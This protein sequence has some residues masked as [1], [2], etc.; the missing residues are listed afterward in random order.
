MSAYRFFE[1]RVPNPYPERYDNVSG[2]EYVTRLVLAREPV[3]LLD[4]KNRK[5]SYIVAEPYTV[6]YL[7]DGRRHELTVPAGMLTD[8]ASVPRAA[9]NVV[10]RVG[11]HLEAAIVHDYLF[12]AWQLIDGR[13]TRRQ[14]F[15]FANAVMFAGLKAARVAYVE[16][17]AIEL[18][19]SLPFVPW[20]AYRS[21]DDVLF[22]QL[23]PQFAATDTGMT[24]PPIFV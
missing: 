21:R 12:N 3:A 6:T 4:K 2:F 23:D 24:G 20:S 13:G 5:A 16:R 18:G 14:D 8:L 19:L 1:P 17:K 10:G 22:V 15:R 7:V 9:R 11:P